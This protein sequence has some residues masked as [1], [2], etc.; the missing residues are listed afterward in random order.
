[1]EESR[2]K[3][4]AKNIGV[5]LSAKLLS[6]FCSFAI[7]TIFLKY[8]GEQ[9]T[10]VS[11]LFTDILNILSFTELGIGTAVS[12]SLYKPIAEKNDYR[13]AQ[14]MKLYKY[15][16]IIISFIVLV[17]GLAFIPF[18]GLF[19]TDVPDI[20]ESITFIYVLYVFKTAI[21]YLL[22]YR[23]TLLI[24]KQKQ[25]IVTGI[26]S[27]GIALK[28]IFDVVLLIF[29]RNFILYL[30]CE[31]A[32][33]L[34]TNIIISVYSKKELSIAE[35][36]VQIDKAD[37]SSLFRDVKNIVIYKINGIVLNSTGS[38]IVSY[39]VNIAS[40]TLL[41]N[42]NMIFNA[43]NGI[44]YQVISS[45]TA[46]V[47][48]LAVQKSND[49]QKRVFLT[50]NFLTFIFTLVECTG[51]WLCTNS[52]VSM[53]WG[54]QYVLSRKI[55]ILLCVN[56]YIVNMHLAVDMFR[57]ANGVFRKGRMRPL[58]TAIINLIVSLVA[59]QYL[60]LFGVI[61]GTVV[62]RISTQA[63]Y[64][65]KLI[66]NLIFKTEVKGYYARYILYFA[67]L[68]ISCLFGT[69]IMDALPDKHLLRFTIGVVYALVFNAVIVVV[70][71]YKTEEF[72]SAYNYARN[73]LNKVK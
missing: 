67:I 70:C 52:F 36:D 38:M 7:R 54:E 2:T 16:Y 73:L 60:G 33:V 5:N 26:Q 53:L 66:F 71:F 48:N 29:T 34:I 21:S 63:W 49:D 14:L 30:I 27:V 43:L 18:L 32:Y 8:L 4:S 37:I 20:K 24:A 61:L 51:L 72:G 23:S 28:T 46:S 40:V 57:T 64:D 31:I 6:M 65:S 58:A 44:V 19:V 11:T 1:M 13:V 25:Y 47:G 41:S 15:I 50:I 42:Y 59:V 62:A 45:M 35:R 68:C 17:V 55:V 12:F 10:G 56:S 39:F 3:K 69:L 9:Y 22:I